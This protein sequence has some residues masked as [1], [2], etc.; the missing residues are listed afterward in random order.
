M[1]YSGKK[2]LVMGLGLHG[3][4]VDT[5][6]FL[7][8][9]GAEVT[10][11][12]L[13]NEKPLSPSIEKLEKVCKKSDEIRYVLGRHEIDDF[14]KADL[15]IKNPGVRTDS[16]F[17]QAAKQIETDISLFLMESPARL[18]AV[19]GSKGKSCAAS[20]LHWILDKAGSRSYLGGNITVSPLTFLD[21]LKTD[22]NVILELSSWQL[23][24]LKNRYTKSG[25]ALL[26]P[27]AAIITAI[28]PDH[29]DSYVSMNH[30]IDDKRII[31]RGQDISDITVAAD[32]TWGRS[33]LSETKGR[34]IIYAHAPLAEGQNGGWINSSGAGVARL[35]NQGEAV[36]LVPEQLNTPGEHQKMNLLA[37]SLAAYSFGIKADIIHKALTDFPGI[38]HRLEM[39][40][41][42][43]GIRFYNDSSATI[44]EAAAACIDALTPLAPLILVTG[45]TDKNLDFS[46]LVKAAGKVKSIILLNGSGTGKLIYEFKK[47][48]IIYKG[49]F[50][51]LEKALDSAMQEVEKGDIIALSPGCTSFGMFQNEFERGIK[52]KNV[53][54]GKTRR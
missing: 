24:D 54:V 21:E 15:V 25:S 46:P 17:L 12:D 18:F 28:M 33:F 36:E 42:A 39:F 8:K 11:T 3:G 50:D 26:K 48:G 23:G 4:G 53:C 20:A 32:D 30:Y 2:V 41:E 44:P 1:D 38:E 10:V 43:D 35:W 6:C 51:S 52:W 45:G 49:P 34:K 29:L 7:V 40:L 14:I 22:D 5:A 37:A 31:Y 19:T 27:A 9:R 16:H 13:K 47:I